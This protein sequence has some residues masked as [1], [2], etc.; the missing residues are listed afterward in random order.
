MLQALGFELLDEAGAPIPRGARGLEKLHAINAK[1]LP[2]V[3]QKCEFR[4]AC[5]VTNPLCGAQGCSA[6]YGPQKGATKESILQMDAWLSRF[7]TLAKSVNPNADPTLAGAGAA[8]GL[9]FAFAA[10]LGARL[11]SGISLVLDAIHA[12]DHIKTADIVLTG[13]GRLDGQSAMGKAPVGVATLAKKH[14]KR[15][16]A[17]AGCVTEEA[18]KCNRAGIDAFFPI[19]RGV[20]T[21][22][23]AMDAENAK[24]NLAATA[25]QAFR[26]IRA[27]EK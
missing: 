4:I 19:L 16:L 23:E 15:V 24:R 21:L 5:D 18:S 12:E 7:A 3:L 2:P 8:G 9:G 13:E 14:G 20:V 10:F 22:D 1:K 25:E 17:F 27:C 11:Q 6:V 26:L